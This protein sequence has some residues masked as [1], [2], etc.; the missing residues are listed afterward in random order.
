MSLIAW[1]THAEVGHAAV[2]Q[3]HDEFGLVRPPLLLSCGVQVLWRRFVFLFTWMYFKVFC[4]KKKA[5][6][7]TVNYFIFRIS[8]YSAY[9]Q[10]IYK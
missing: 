4:K 1:L 9:V 8:I 6:E 10:Y 5:F 2:S 7:K 3:D